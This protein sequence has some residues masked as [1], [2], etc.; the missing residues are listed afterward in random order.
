[1]LIDGGV[2]ETPRGECPAVSTALTD[3]LSCDPY[4][5]ARKSHTNSPDSFLNSKRRHRASIR[6]DIGG[7][8]LGIGV[9]PGRAPFRSREGFRSECR[10]KRMPE[11]AAVLTSWAL[12]VVCPA[13]RF[14]AF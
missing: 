13:T 12:M 14:V 6:Q 3:K 5:E 1:M 9:P 2:I 4:A 7:Q 11:V 8:C 10:T